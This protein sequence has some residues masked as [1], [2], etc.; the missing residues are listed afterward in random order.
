VIFT[1]FWGS[2]SQGK[3]GPKNWEMDIL[4]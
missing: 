2:F 3:R 1:T 4:C